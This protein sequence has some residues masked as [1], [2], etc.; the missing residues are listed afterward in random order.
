MNTITQILIT[1][2]TLGAIFVFVSA[3]IIGVK[4]QGAWR[5][6]FMFTLLL[7]LGVY[8]EVKKL[9]WKRALLGFSPTEFEKYIRENKTLVPQVKE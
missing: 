1:L 8:D 7:P 4:E 5:T 9:G 6:L 3:I 2:I